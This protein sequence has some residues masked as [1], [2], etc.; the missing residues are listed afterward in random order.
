[1][2]NWGPNLEMCSIDVPFLSVEE[3]DLSFENTISKPIK[4]ND[5]ELLFWVTKVVGS[6]AGDSSYSGGEKS[7]DFENQYGRLW[8]SC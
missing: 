7:H 1:M 8:T 3:D 2:N 4:E 6:V 5:F